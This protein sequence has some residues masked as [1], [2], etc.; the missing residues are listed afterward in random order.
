MAYCDSMNVWEKT[1]VDK[2]G[3]C[4][5]P[6]MIRDYIGIRPGFKVLWI[7][8]DKKKP[9]NNADEYLINIAII[10]KK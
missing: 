2:K 1:I 7:S 10:P 6:Q 8:A 9:T 5:I 4:V 3:K